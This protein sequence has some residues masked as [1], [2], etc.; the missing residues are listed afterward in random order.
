M[1]LLVTGGSGFLGR[2]VVATAI[3]R[4]DKVIGLAR[5]ADA[6]GTLARLGAATVRADLDDPVGTRQAFAA[7]GADALLNLAS[8][9]FGH[10]GTIVDAAH[11][12][13]LRRAVFVSTTAVTTRLDTPT[14]AIRIAAEDRVRA[15]GLDWTIVRP[16]MIYGGPDDRNMCRLL[17]LLRRTRVVPLPAGGRGLHQPV[18]VDDLAELLI[19]AIRTDRAVAHRYDIAGPRPLSLRQIVEVAAAALGRRVWFVPVPLTPTMRLVGL[20]GAVAR[21][22]FPPSHRPT[23]ADGASSAGVTHAGGR[24]GGRRRWLTEEQIAR[25]AEDKVFSLAAA[26]ADLGFAPRE[27]ADGIRAQAGRR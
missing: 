12:A 21:V 15:S 24:P 4:G 3:A 6:A 19:H 9:G 2:R 20:A 14:K 13:G 17:A 5:S 22:G 27:F 1:R 25:L 10:A 11:A 23:D 8:L 18:H 26:Q 16:T 7:A